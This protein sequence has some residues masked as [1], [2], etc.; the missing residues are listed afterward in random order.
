MTPPT[1]TE[2]IRYTADGDL[3]K[4]MGMKELPFKSHFSM[5]PLIKLIEK[6]AKDGNQSEAFL[7]QAILD[8][9]EEAP[10]FREPIQ[11]I[12]VIKK[13]MEIAEMMML[14]LI[15]PAGRD[16]RL[17]KI[18]PPFSMEPIYFTPALQ[19]MMKNNE[20]NLILPGGMDKMYCA[21]V[22]KACT[23]ILNRFYDQEIE[24]DQLISLTV[25]EEDTNLTRYFKTIVDLDFIEIEAT[26]PLKPLSQQ[27]INELLSNIYDINLWLKYLPPENFAFHGFMVGQL[28][29]ITEE[30]SLSRIKFHLLGQDAVMGQENVEK[31]ESLL[32]TY[33]RQ[34]DLR[35]GITAIDYPME[36]AVS[37]RYRIRFDFLAHK[38][39][40]LLN[41]AN[42]NSIY[43]KVCKYR[44]ILLIE[45]LESVSNKTPIE[46][47]LISEGIKSI[48]VA[49]LKNKKGNIIGILEIGSPRPFQIHSFIEL[50]FKQIVDLF[51]MAVERSRDEVDNRIEA[52]I[53][54]KYTAVHPSVEWKFI[55]NAFSILENREK[56]IS[57]EPP[58]ILF[59]DVYPLYGQADIV[60]S[61]DTRNDAIQADMR[62]NLQLAN[63]TIK[64]CLEVIRYPLLQQLRMYIEQDLKTL[65][66]EFNSSDESR[67]IE[68]LQGEVHPIF[69]QISHNHGELS[70]FIATY[71]GRL[72]PEFNIV[73]KKRRA[74]EDSV[75]MI[76]RTISKYLEKEQQEMQRLLP[77]YFE[78]YKTDGVEY[79][80]YLGQSL[81]RRGVFSEM[82]LQ[83]FRLWQMIHMCE[84]TRIVDNLQTKLEVP[85]V[86]AQLIF[87]YT[88]SL[89]IRFRMDEKQFDVDGAYNVRYEILKK[90]I[91]KATINGTEERLTQAG[92]VAIVYLQEKDRQE[93]LRYI[94]FLK[95]EDYIEDEV[96][97]LE[98]NKLQSVQGLKALRVTVKR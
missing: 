8:R 6:R 59:D 32:R 60:G 98:I 53:R 76:N 88:N 69:R 4:E 10:E 56:D 39:E 61:S 5:I 80:L 34:P 13:N 3:F 95:H 47:D 37:H 50:K 38:H 55:E 96:E 62:T 9:L 67:I 19:K 92:K 93:Y 16:K 48:I 81:L 45:D 30:E 25:N 44:E 46:K 57:K 68:L 14:F 66:G 1:K 41:D 70:G 83:N 91:D 35:M 40:C 23:F 58:S 52:I 20:V 84:I 15:P 77:H 24:D 82:H 31:L 7:A 71:F 12:S 21:N 65:D 18:S 64:K 94:E 90:R 29:D 42:T 11:D 74:Y 26:K 86:T 89:S 73:Y 51:A 87:A 63:H 79:D 78:K 17:A 36:Q 72:D 43:E 28:T 2:N 22:I 33:F 75:A 27:Q 97:D 85:L 54:E 49:P